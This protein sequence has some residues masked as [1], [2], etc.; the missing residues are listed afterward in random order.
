MHAKTSSSKSRIA[1]LLEF[2]LFVF[3][4]VRPILL[5]CEFYQIIRSKENIAD[6]SGRHKCDEETDYEDW[7]EL[8]S[9]RKSGY[10]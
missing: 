6:C 2:L 1:H 9:E 5:L 10:E 4:V 8:D 3:S 7:E